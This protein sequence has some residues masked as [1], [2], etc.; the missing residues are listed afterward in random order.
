MQENEYRIFMNHK[1]RI[2]MDAEGIV[3]FI[4]TGLHGSG[5]FKEQMQI[6]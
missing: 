1:I 5:T 3:K 4:G 6:S 2:S